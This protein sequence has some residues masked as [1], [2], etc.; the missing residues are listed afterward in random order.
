VILADLLLTTLQCFIEIG[1]S[2]FP[3]TLSKSLLGGRPASPPLLCIYEYWSLLQSTFQTS[4]WGHR[5]SELSQVVAMCPSSHILGQ[6]IIV[7]W[8]DSG[9]KLHSE[10][11]KSKGPP[12]RHHWIVPFFRSS[13]N[14]IVHLCSHRSDQF[15]TKQSKRSTFTTPLFTKV[16][17]L[18]VFTYIF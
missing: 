17:S 8:S 11:G 14:R 2:P 18:L 3:I 9:T 13:L 5:A 15:Y 12:A 16:C 6:G 10:S 7:L 1:N 4:A